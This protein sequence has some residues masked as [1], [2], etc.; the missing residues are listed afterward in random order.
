MVFHESLYYG[1]KLDHSLIN[2]NQLRY[3][4]IQ[5]NDNPYNKEK[6]LNI[7]INN[8]L[9]ID[10]QSSGTKVRFETRVPTQSE[11]SSCERIIYN[12]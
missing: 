7:T 9:M 1:T 4:G 5:Y 8:D 6:G 2:P 11:M 3:Y 10:M 12:D